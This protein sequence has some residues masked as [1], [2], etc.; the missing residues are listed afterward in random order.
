M[1]M[2]MPN[3]EKSG[4]W[5]S[6]PQGRV[7]GGLRAVDRK[8]RLLLVDNDPGDRQDLR[9][10][11][12]AAPDIELAGETAGG[13]EAVESIQLLRPD[14]VVIDVDMPEMPVTEVIRTLTQTH[15]GVRV[16]VV[17]AGR[18]KDRLREARRAGASAFVVKDAGAGVLLQTISDLTRDDLP[19]PSSEDPQ[20]PVT[21]PRPEGT[22]PL[23][24]MPPPKGTHPPRPRPGS[25]GTDNLLTANERA[26]L[27]LLAQG[28]TN[29]EIGRHTGLR[30]SMVGTYLSE[31]Y[32]KLG[33]SG[34]EDAIRFA[35]ER[36]GNLDS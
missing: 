27:K 23:P 22:R 20:P 9:A 7:R 2:V 17:T 3:L 29:P 10:A 35:R 8:I 14:I 13:P 32:R 12:D 6:Y 4:I 26:I 30:E 36:L 33:L 15:A 19:L 25:L 31:I 18:D 34:R 5:T 1:G 11:L 21:D 28:L 24:P 16:V